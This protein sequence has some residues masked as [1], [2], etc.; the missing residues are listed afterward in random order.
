METN[1]ILIDLVRNKVLAKVKAQVSVDLIGDALV[2]SSTATQDIVYTY[3]YYI[4]N[5]QYYYN[6]EELA[7]LIAR[8]YYKRYKRYIKNLFFKEKKRLDIL[9][10]NLYN[11]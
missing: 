8:K 6:N 10:R 1:D 2:V 11:R 9:D 3:T 4:Y 5:N 7:N